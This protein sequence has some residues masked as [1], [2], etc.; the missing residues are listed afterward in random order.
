MYV[1]GMLTYVFVFAMVSLKG[2][3][4]SNGFR[5]NFRGVIKDFQVSLKPLNPLPL[6]LSDRGSQTLFLYLN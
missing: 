4:T 3:R 2:M 5:E 6:S 1:I